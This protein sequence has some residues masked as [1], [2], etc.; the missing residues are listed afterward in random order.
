MAAQYRQQPIILTRNGIT[1]DCAGLNPDQIRKLINMFTVR[2]K[3]NMGQL[4]VH[5]NVIKTRGSSVMLFP[6]FGFL[7]RLFDGSLTKLAGIHP[8]SLAV[9]LNQQQTDPSLTIKDPTFQLKEHQIVIINHIINTSYNQVNLST[10]KAGLITQVDTGYG[11]TYI[12]IG[13]INAIKQNTLIIVHNKPQAED[14]YKICASTFGEEN[15][16]SYNSARKKSGKILIM[17]VQSALLESYN[18]NKS[19]KN[20]ISRADRKAGK[21]DKKVE[22]DQELTVDQMFNKFGFV[23]FDEC[24]KYC[25]K[26]FSQVFTRTQFTFMLGLSATPTNGDLW[27][28]SEWNIGPIRIMKDELPI[29]ADLKE[30]FT[31][32]IHVINYYGPRSHTMQILNAQGQS[33]HIAMIKQILDDPHRNYW[34]AMYLLNLAHSGRNIYVFA[35]ILE[36]L[37]HIRTILLDYIKSQQTQQNIMIL[38][39][40]ELKQAEAKYS[41]VDDWDEKLSMLT[42][43]AKTDDI[44]RVSQSSK[45]IFST[46]GY[47]GTG[48][49]IPRMDTI[50]FA[51]PHKT[52]TA[53]YIGRIFRPGPNQ[54]VPRLIVDIV[55]KRLKL[56]SQFSSRKRIYNEQE[57][58]GRHLTMKTHPVHAPQD[59]P[60]PSEAAESTIADE[61][62]RDDELEEL[63][64]LS[65][66]D[67]QEDLE[68]LKRA[69]QL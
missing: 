43:G 44:A 65:G 24:H 4:I 33:N 31:G 39:E 30:E 67:E 21:P 1:Y 45:I 28:I 5:S 51:T 6:R 48:K 64:E 20:K 50:L 26:K 27:Q 61:E 23:I 40:D 3:V 29:L 59:N 12:G 35:V 62:E 58:I 55:D 46:Y 47:M 9:R 63:E 11:K 8:N 54:Q 32:E 66:D 60:T 34:I 42:G 19:G 15:V 53:Q 56:S 57:Q 22:I 13:L 52:G 16:G 36:G 69:F 41:A 10:G 14:W 49:S 25:S 37:R 17:T 68:E 18:F 7:N 38:D 2:Y